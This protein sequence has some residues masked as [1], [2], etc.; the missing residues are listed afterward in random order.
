MA[1][2]MYPEFLTDLVSMRSMTFI[3]RVSDDDYVSK[4]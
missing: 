2:I 3:I 4:V 1:K